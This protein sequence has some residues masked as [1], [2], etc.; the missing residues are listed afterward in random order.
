MRISALMLAVLLASGASGGE[1]ATLLRV[2][3]TG[4]AIEGC[5]NL[6]GP[7]VEFVFKVANELPTI[8][9]RDPSAG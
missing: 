8:A 1:P 9:F 3:P 4:T 2:A 7:A 5:G 6:D